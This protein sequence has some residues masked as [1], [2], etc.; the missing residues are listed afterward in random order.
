MPMTKGNGT[1]L[2]QAWER[3]RKGS[4][5]QGRK[6]GPVYTGEKLVLRLK[7]LFKKEKGEEKREGM[8]KEERKKGERGR[9]TKE[10]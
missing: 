2:C 10:C 8:G 1:S 4:L 3:N 6:D 7:E 5:C 9:K